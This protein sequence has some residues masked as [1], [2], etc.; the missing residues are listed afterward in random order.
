[1][2]LSGSLL[3]L[4]FLLPMFLQGLRGLSAQQSGLATFPQALGVMTMARVAGNLYPKIVP[5]RLMMFGS[6][7]NALVTLGFI[8]VPPSEPVMIPYALA[9]LK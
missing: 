7:T 4:L 6:L 9:A 2:A 3:G 8:F 5:R 1:M